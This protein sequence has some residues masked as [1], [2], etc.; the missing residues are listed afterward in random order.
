MNP[1]SV[2]GYN[3]GKGMTDHL[4][5]IEKEVLAEPKESPG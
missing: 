4:K 2:L 3:T 5:K 1:L